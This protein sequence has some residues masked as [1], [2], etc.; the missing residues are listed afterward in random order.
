MHIGRLSTDGSRVASRGQEPVTT[1][2]PRLGQETRIRESGDLVQRLSHPAGPKTLKN[3]LRCLSA[4]AARLRGR[5]RLRESGDLVQHLSHPAGPKTLKNALSCLSAKAA[6]LRERA[7]LRES[8]DL[9]QRLSHPAGPKTLKNAL[10][11]LSAKAARLRGRA[12]RRGP[13]CQSILSP[14]AQGSN[15]STNRQK[16]CPSRQGQGRSMVEGGA[17]EGKRRIGTYTKK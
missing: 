13:G 2:P 11:C 17:P 15:A 1:A 9:V 8:G 7:R 3:A 16:P 5:A 4:K 10:G 6:R 14:R 12:R